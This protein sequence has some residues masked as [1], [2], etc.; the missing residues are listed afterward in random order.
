ME[1]INLVVWDHGLTKRIEN[2]IYIKPQYS[3]LLPFW[4]EKVKQ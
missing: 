1:P 2:E 4:E 3:F